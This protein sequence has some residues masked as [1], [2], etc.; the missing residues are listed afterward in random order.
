[1][2]KNN[3]IKNNMIKNNMIK[4]NN[5]TKKKKGQIIGQIFVYILVVIVVGGIVLVG[6]WAIKTLLEKSCQVEQITF[7]SNLE[8]ILEKSNTFGSVKRESLATPCDYSQVCLVDASRIGSN[9]N[10]GNTIISGSVFDKQRMNI[11]IV[12]NKFT[13]PIGYSEYISLD[14]VDRCLCIN[15]T[16]KRFYFTFNGRG[17]TTLVTPNAYGIG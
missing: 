7:K 11:F 6:Y 14:P 1:M 9:I 4:N 8:K 15:S 16:N 10:C 3:M 13:Y 12:S 2:I 5:I 17:S